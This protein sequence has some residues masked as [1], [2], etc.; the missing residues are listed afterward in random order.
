MNK[1]EKMDMVNFAVFCATILYGYAFNIVVPAMLTGIA[2]IIFLNLTAVKKNFSVA[3]P[4]QET[5][6]KEKNIGS[7]SADELR[8]ELLNVQRA[9]LV[10]EGIV[11]EMRQKKYAGARKLVKIASP[12][13]YEMAMEGESYEARNIY[14]QLACVREF[15]RI[16]D[17]FVRIQ[18]LMTMTQ[19]GSNILEEMKIEG[20]LKYDQT[21]WESKRKRVRRRQMTEDAQAFQN[22]K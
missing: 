7:L 18:K 2:T 6:A 20:L 22:K 3:P 19:R 13:D 4:E 12:E 1:I 8:E 9:A 11:L 21:I 5:E 17:L 14:I 16:D 15:R 10:M